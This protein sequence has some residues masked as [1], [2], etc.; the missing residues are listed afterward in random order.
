M[1]LLSLLF[2]LNTTMRFALVG[3]LTGLGF[4][5]GILYTLSLSLTILF[6][7]PCV[8]VFLL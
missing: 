6:F 1:S 5:R 3:W 8:L 4:S 2:Y 7:V